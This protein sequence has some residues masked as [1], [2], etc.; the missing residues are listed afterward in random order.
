MTP[1]E[2]TASFTTAAAN[3]QPIHGQPTDDDLTNLRNVIYPLLLEIPY[4]E[5]GDHNLI[6]LIEPTAAYTN[7]WGTAFP[8]PVRPPAYPVIANDATAVIRAR[9]EAEHAVRVR[10]FAS[11]EA[12][13]RA[14]AKFIRDAVNELWYRDLRHPRSFYITVSAKQLIEHL[15]TN[16]GGLH[17]TELVNLPTEMMTYYATAEGIPEYINMLEDAQSKLERANLPIP[18]NNLLAIASTAVLAS[19]HYPRPTDEWEAKPRH[20]KTWDNWK[21]HYRAAHLARKRQLLAA[22][23]PPFQHAANAATTHDT[24]IDPTTFDRLD[25]YL[26]NLAAAATSER[27]TLTQLIDNNASL[28]ASV[29]ALTASVTALTAA[30]TLMTNKQTHQTP[31]PRTSNAMQPK[32]TPFDPSYCWTHGYKVRPGHT[33]VTCPAK[34]TGHQEA[35]THANN[36]GGSTLFKPRT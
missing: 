21:L 19:D 29:A 10:D 30:Y 3:F 36:M 31:R 27:T 14:A 12:A 33:S 11:Y 23:Q 35:A 17:P 8:I 28:T 15:D 18:D 24:T 25:G 22:T 4:D 26:D 1:E 2:I 6:G 7:T 9:T 34:A 32:K 16:C 5:H 13:E 20:E